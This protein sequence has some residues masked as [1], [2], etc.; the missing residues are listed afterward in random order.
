MIVAAV[1]PTVSRRRS[2]LEQ[3]WNAWWWWNGPPSAG[4]VYST[5]P[6]GTSA[7]ASCKVAVYRS[8]KPNP[9]DPRINCW[10]CMHTLQLGLLGLEL[11]HCFAHEL[12]TRITHRAA[13]TLQP[14]QTYCQ[15]LRVWYCMQDVLKPNFLAIMWSHSGPSS[16]LKLP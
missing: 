3:V 15:T 7:I 9:S 2:K 8:N 4:P 10:P 6:G 13:T 12:L 14:S 16:I 1:A 5:F 11:V